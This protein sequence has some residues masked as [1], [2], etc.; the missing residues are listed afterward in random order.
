MTMG[1]RKAFSAL[2][3]NK[4]TFRN[5]LEHLSLG[6]ALFSDQSHKPSCR[7]KKKSKFKI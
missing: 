4:E 7:K 3:L 5:K 2:R 1:R 6:I